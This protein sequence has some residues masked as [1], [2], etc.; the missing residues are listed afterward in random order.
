METT[1][2]QDLKDEKV[3]SENRAKI[4]AERTA[5]AKTLLIKILTDRKIS[6]CYSENDENF[7]MEFLMFT[8]KG[9]IRQFFAYNKETSSLRI[10][11][12]FPI[13]VPK[14]KT[15]DILVLLNTLNNRGFFPC[16]SIDEG[17][18]IS[19]RITL[20]DADKFDNP[21]IIM[22][23]LSIECDIF[24]DFFDQITSVIFSNGNGSQK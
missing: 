13:A 6:Y 12:Q 1:E 19:I 14:D 2:A 5:S 18:I 4:I 17:G 7:F 9:I 15:G 21:D 22:F 8:E 3:A 10:F 24:K 16:L 11:S 20:L 23:A